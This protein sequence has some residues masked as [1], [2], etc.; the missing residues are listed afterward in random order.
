LTAEKL[1][2][3]MTKAA[4]ILATVSVPLVILAFWPMYLSRPLAG[5]DPYTHLHAI[6]G[7]LW[8]ALLIIQP[9]AIH[10]YRWHRVHRNVGRC[11]YVLAAL[12][13]V[14]GILLSHHRLVSMDEATFAAEGYSHYLP[15]Y[16]SIVFAAAYL[17]G[18]WFRQMPAAH[19]RFMLLTAIPLIDPVIGRILFFYLPALPHPLLYQAA[20]FSVETVLAVLIVFSYQGTGK[21][22]GALVAYFVLL[23]TLEI[24]WFTFARTGLWLETVAYFRSLPLS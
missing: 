21:A 8:M 6:A 4:G 10:N 11:S 20:T 5:S 16:A 12:F 22:R 24:G 13:F 18:L 2:M 15:F 9:I 17:L 23:V 19:G 14:A 1:N 7:S 3:Q